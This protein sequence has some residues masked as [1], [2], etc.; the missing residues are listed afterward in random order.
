MK[1]RTAKI[2]V[3][4]DFETNTA[5]V[6]IFKIRNY[7]L[8]G[9]KIFELKRDSY[10]LNQIANLI[11]KYQIKND[12]VPTLNKNIFWNGKSNMAVTY[13]LEFPE[14]LT[15]KEKESRETYLLGRDEK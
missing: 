6:R 9:G 14:V 4:T 7:M 1:N 8:S 5:L 12:P 3:S 15:E 11:E 13:N 2:L 10:A